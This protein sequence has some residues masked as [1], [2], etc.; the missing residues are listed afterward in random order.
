MKESIIGIQGERRE[1]LKQGRPARTLLDIYCMVFAI[2]AFKDRGGSSQLYSAKGYVL[3]GLANQRRE[4]A[5]GTEPRDEPAL[6]A[7]L[8][9]HNSI[10]FTIIYNIL[11][12]LHGITHLLTETTP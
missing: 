10:R 9:S 12:Y 7:I 8:F 4:F 3:E 2:E 11:R 1:A 6:H 5:R